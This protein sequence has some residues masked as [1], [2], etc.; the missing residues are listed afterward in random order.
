MLGLL[1]E[2][3]WEEGDA[4]ASVENHW[5]A[6][7]HYLRGAVGSTA[8]FPTDLEELERKEIHISAH[9]HG[10]SEGFFLALLDTSHYRKILNT[11]SY[12]HSVISNRSA[13][14]LPLQEVPDF[15]SLFLTMV[16]TAEMLL[17]LK[18]VSLR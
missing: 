14:Y 3:K 9:T 16:K 17:Y 18:R 5:I 10:I 7:F 13:Y 4:I 6:A 2:Y 12:V 8:A 1:E 15:Q 11:C